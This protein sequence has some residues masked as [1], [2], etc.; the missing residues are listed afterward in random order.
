MMK[1]PEQLED[2]STE[3]SMVNSDFDWLSLA[4][5]PIVE[6]LFPEEHEYRDDGCDLFP[7]CLN[8]PFPVCRYDEPG[9]K[10]HWA[11]RL[12]DREVLRSY[13]KE[14]TSVKELARR[15]GLSQR[16]IYRI[17]RRALS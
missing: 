3:A 1:E 6:D 12:R 11:K 14:G 9:T 17:I 16:T 7:S 2:G 8:C 5:G 10:V 13:N 4:V 15:Y